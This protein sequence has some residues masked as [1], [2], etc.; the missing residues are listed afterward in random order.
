M[1]FVVVDRSLALESL[2]LWNLKKDS[3][4]YKV[5]Q[6]NLGQEDHV[7]PTMVQY[8]SEASLANLVLILEKKFIENHKSMLDCIRRGID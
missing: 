5:Y 2:D 3:D 7:R 8:Q 1:E 4:S 6:R